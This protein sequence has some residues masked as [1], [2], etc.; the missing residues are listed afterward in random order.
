MAP[1]FYHVIITQKALADLRRLAQYVRDDSPQNASLIATMILESIDS[2]R[3]MPC[4]FPRVD[5]SR[6]R[7]SEIR[8]LVVT[9]FIIY[10]RVDERTQ[11]VPI[12][13]ICHGAQKQ[14][15][16]FGLDSR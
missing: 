1:S 7:G 6:K 5:T 14:P 9:P 16:R 15:R 8:R 4:R 13:A 10:Y 2:L 12:I 3:S 11:S